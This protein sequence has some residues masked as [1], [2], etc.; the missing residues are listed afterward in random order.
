[1]R[2]VRLQEL[3]WGWV[4]N[5]SVVKCIWRER[6]GLKGKGMR[7][8]YPSDLS[9]GTAECW[10]SVL[11]WLCR[12]VSWDMKRTLAL[13]ISPFSMQIPFLEAAIWSLI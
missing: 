1:M 5:S 4:V 3:G 13:L 9:H 11:T 2:E 12:T 10:H 7:E 6:D 8:L